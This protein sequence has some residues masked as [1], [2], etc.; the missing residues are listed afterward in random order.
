MSDS[1]AG[2]L[3]IGVLLLFVLATTPHAAADSGNRE[4]AKGDLIALQGQWTLIEFTRYDAGTAYTQPRDKTEGLL[5]VKG[6]TYNL[7]L[8]LLEQEVDRDYK[9]KLYAGR[10]PKAFDVTIIEDGIL[11]EGIYAIKGNILRRCYS[12]PGTPRPEK[13]QTGDQTY[14]VWKRKTSSSKMS[15]PT[16]ILETTLAG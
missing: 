13:F 6:N 14:Q 16:A 5:T 2:A 1:S 4:V 3:R 11:I 9:L 10:D 15:R 12:R 7:K 8:K